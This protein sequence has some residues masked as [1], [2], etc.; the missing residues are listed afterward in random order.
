[1]KYKVVI[2]SY[3]A[4]TVAQVQHID[5]KEQKPPGLKQNTVVIIIIEGFKYGLLLCLFVGKD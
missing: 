5:L 4:I 1:M 3:G 2:N